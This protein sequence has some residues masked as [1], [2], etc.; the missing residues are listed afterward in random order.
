MKAILF[1]RINHSYLGER[2]Q[3]SQQN[4]KKSGRGN[5][6]F[7]SAAALGVTS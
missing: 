3:Y 4:K 6:R 1:L 5:F 2:A 7:W